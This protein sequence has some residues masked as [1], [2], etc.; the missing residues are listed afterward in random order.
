MYEDQ[1]YDIIL[2]GVVDVTGTKLNG[3]ASNM[4]LTE[5]CIP[6]L[7]GVSA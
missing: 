7:G 2:D 4:T 5:F 6:K 3:T 1:T